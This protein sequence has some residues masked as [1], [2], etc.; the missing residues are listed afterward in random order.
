[1]IEIF[2]SNKLFNEF[3]KY[4]TFIFGGGISLLIGLGITYV[5]TRYVGLWHMFSYTIAIF[6]EI[7]FLFFYHTHI[8]FKT[9]GHILKFAFNILFISFLNWVFVYLFSVTFGINYLVSIVFV[10]LL[11][12]VINYSMNKVFIFNNKNKLV[13]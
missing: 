10:A 4:F 7:I 13:K 8:T 12:S 11:I 3:R 2:K 9:K 5:F 1:M 6:F